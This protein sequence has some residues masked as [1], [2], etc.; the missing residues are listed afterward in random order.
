VDA[1]VGA[2]VKNMRGR[3]EATNGLRALS[4]SAL[5]V[6]NI[7][8]NI[9][10]EAVSNLAKAG[11]SADAGLTA[12][13]TG[14]VGTMIGTLGDGGVNKTI[15]TTT[16]GG[17]TQSA[18]E[19][20]KATG[21]STDA[22]IAVAVQS[23]TKGAVS[24]VT[25]LTVGGVSSADYPSLAAAISK[26]AAVAL[27]T[28]TTDATKAASLVGA[29]ATGAAEGVKAVAV[30]S[31]VDPAV[32]P[33]MIQQTTAGTTLGVMD[34]FA[35]V[36][37]STTLLQTVTS[38]ISQQLLIGEVI[39]QT[40]VLSQVTQGA[41]AAAQVIPTGALDATALATAIS[42]TLA[43]GT[44]QAP[45]PVIIAA[46]IAIGTNHPPVATAGA[47]QSVFIGAAVTLDGTGSSDADTGD[48]LSYSWTLVSKP[49]TSSC[50]LTNATS[51]T[52]GF[53]PDVVGT[54]ILSLKVSDGKAD[55]ESFCTITVVPPSAVLVSGVS[56]SP[57]SAS[58]L[59]GGTQ[60]LTAT[61][62]PSNA[63]NKSVTWAS[64]DQ[65]VAIVSPSGLVTGMGSGTATITVTTSEGGKSATCAVAVTVPVSGV[66][67]SPT[68]A[69][70]VVGETLQLTATV[71]PSGATN[72]NVTWSST[73]QAVATVS[74]AGLVTA[75]AEGSATITVRTEDGNKTA[76]SVIAVTTPPLHVYITGAVGIS[77]SGT[78][79]YWKDEN[80]YSLPMGTGAT[81]G[82]AYCIALDSP[83]NVYIAGTMSVSGSQTPVY[84]KNGNLY[85][86]P[87]GTG[88]TYGNAFGVAVDAS[89]NVYIAGA[90]GTSSSTVMPVYWKN[91]VPHSLPMGTGDT[92]GQAFGVAVDA[93]GNVYIAGGTGVSGTTVPA[94]WKNEIL[95][96]LPMDTGATSGNNYCIA[97]DASGN[98]YIAGAES[99]SG[100]TTPVYWKNDILHT[101]PMST[102]ATMA[103]AV[104][105]AVDSTGNV[106][107]AGFAQI[108]S[109]M[110][111]V[112]WKNDI[113]YSLPLGTGNTMGQAIG[114]SVDASG[115]VYIA[116]VVGI[117]SQLPAY[118]K[119]ENIY[120]LPMGTGNTMGYAYFI[121]VGK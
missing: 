23:V 63:T 38:N 70:L 50:S 95:H 90:A 22:A 72:T 65:A 7:L 66:S 84:W 41:A 56:V 18:V 81:N 117:G 115:N 20:L 31:G 42:L 82:L 59:Q 17:I 54:Y 14:V 109:S 24:A 40:D 43:D 49:S 94:Y 87:M 79:A 2:F 3:F 36:V 97:V 106:Y 74:A 45:D 100:S 118:W 92:R 34:S 37:N 53:T 75:V 55:S 5:V 111:P 103:Q 98:V 101:L 108:S 105:I 61:I 77:G 8:V 13:A 93:S 78:T 67:V 16:L 69:S 91:E 107:F 28:L 76:T 58:I 9:S 110:A 83:G 51:G 102:G 104:G 47:D 119:N 120:S 29:V 26:S 4:P 57:T 71:S 1:I 48:T 96:S 19:S 116:G 44:A 121:A 86:L 114:V 12:A 21:L 10:K 89:G 85:S 88:N 15:A 113:L 30:T 25:S 99:I 62:A 35:T 73:D 46:G 60:Q 6:S 52:S 80:L 64:S 68:T 27:G 32:I 33:S 11:F 112:Y 39:P